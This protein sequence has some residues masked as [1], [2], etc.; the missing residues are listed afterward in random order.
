MIKNNINNML[1]SPL[2]TMAG[3]GNNELVTR[4]QSRFPN[5]HS[6]FLRFAKKKF[7]GLLLSFQK[8]KTPLKILYLFL[9]NNHICKRSKKGMHS[10]IISLLTT[11]YFFAY[12]IQKKI[13]AKKILFVSLENPFQIFGG[14][15]FAFLKGIMYDIKLVECIPLTPKKER[16]RNICELF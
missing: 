6:L 15:F 11:K 9:Q 7:L 12:P 4:F 10:K 14:I 8:N 3:V 13:K 5:P 1:L 16:L 2:S